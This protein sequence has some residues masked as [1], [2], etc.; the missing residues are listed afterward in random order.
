MSEYYSVTTK[1][2]DA[3]IANAI[4]NNKKLNITHVAFGDG[5]GSVP[6]PDKNRT[7]L[8]REVHRQAVNKYTQHETV[9]NWITVEVIIPS[10]IGGFYIREVGIIAEGVLISDG[11]VP[12]TYKEAT[13]DG[14]RE[15]RLRLTIDIQSAEVVSLILDESLIYASQKWVDEN[16]IRRNEIVDNLTTD[17]AK[18]PLSAKQGK[19]LQDNKFD[20]KGGTVTG[21]VTISNGELIIK[22]GEAS[23]IA[24][25][26]NPTSS[27]T[28]NSPPNL[29]AIIHAF[30]FKWYETDYQIGNIRGGSTN[31][32]GFG[33]TQSN[34]KLLWRVNETGQYSYV[35]LYV[36][37]K[38]QADK[39]V[40]ALN[41]N[42]DTATK[43][44][45]ARTMQFSGAATGSFNYDGSANASCVLT[46]TNSGVVASTY[47]SSLKVPTITVNAK[48]LISGVSEKDIPIIN[49]LA[50]GGSTNILSAEQGKI[51]GRTKYNRSS[52]SN[53]IFDLTKKTFDGIHTEYTWNGAPV[54]GIGACQFFNYSQDWIGKLFFYIPANKL[55][56]QSLQAGKTT[57]VWQEIA[58]VDGN[59]AS[60]TK[61]QNIRK[62]FGYDFDG[63]KDLTDT[64]AINCGGTGANNAA[65]ARLNLGIGLVATEDILPVSKGG[66]GSTTAS[67][68]RVN[69]GLGSAAEKNIGLFSGGVLQ[70]G[71]AGFA[72]RLVADIS[73]AEIAP[74][75][76]NEIQALLTSK[77]PLSGNSTFYFCQNGAT[78]GSGNGFPELYGTLRGYHVI[79][80]N[81]SYSF[82][83]FTGING[84]RQYIRYPTSPTAW[85]AFR[86]ISYTDSNITGNAATASKLQTA[87]TIQFSGAATG[88]FSYDGSANGSCVLTLTNSG[89][90]ASTYGS[91]LKVPTITVNAK[92]LIS[93]ISEKD[94]PIINDLTTGGSTNILSAEQGKALQDNKLNKTDN[95]VSASKLQTARTIQF[96]GAAT[97]SFNFDG[98]QNIICSLS[99]PDLDIL[100]YLP[101]PYPKAIPPSGYLSLAGQSIIQSQYPKLYDLYGTTLPDMRGEFIR[102]FDNGRGVDLGRSILSWQDDDL[103]SHT[104]SYFQVSGGGGGQTSG[105]GSSYNNQ[106]STSNTGGTETRPRNISFNYIVKAG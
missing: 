33:I 76:P 105:G 82:Q 68:A 9:A 2:G 98:S 81:Y 6:T 100:P 28:A 3:A 19:E 49:D 38:V 21:G 37:G 26:L 101:Q 77:Y 69:L 4:T 104:H 29:A 106:V 16:Y 35:D 45:T 90:V 34:N 14:V 43:L 42:A 88:S 54:N 1:V 93:G 15:Y 86:E 79:D 85:S 65:Q 58:Y 10:N 59:V 27:I 22:T 53:Q 95:A 12:P 36:S 84:S 46:L 17:D 73:I 94:I 62:I 70:A 55:Y 56:V 5:N 41:G 89:V 47:G 31:S 103:R 63:T 39:F 7:A 87:R 64:I 13:N 50:T 74:K 8:V 48:G 18:K 83:I 23:P 44:Q 80:N 25:V 61:L 71:A 51:L 60:A 96:S 75:L 40:G 24:S 102:G 99:N 91:S 78:G 30:S 92:G 97:G 67:N 52:S 72:S 32:M 20:K 66:T 57:T 11:S